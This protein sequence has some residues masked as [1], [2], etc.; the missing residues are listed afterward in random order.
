MAALTSNES[1]GAH[2][3]MLGATQEDTP[4]MPW[5]VPT[6]FEVRA[7]TRF[8]DSLLVVGSSPAL[9]SWEPENGLRMSTSASLYPV[10]R[11]DPLLLNEDGLEF[12]FVI[13]RS[14]GS[15][16]WEERGNRRLALRGA[17][18]TQVIAEW[19][20]DDAPSTHPAMPL[21]FFN[22]APSH[23]LPPVDQASS[24]HMNGGASRFRLIPPFSRSQSGK[25]A[26]GANPSSPSAA[27]VAAPN[28]GVRAAPLHSHTLASESLVLMTNRWKGCWWSSII[29]RSC[30]GRKGAHG[31]A[32]G[33]TLRYSPPPFRAVA[34]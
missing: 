13:R 4:P 12:K 21:P 10:W 5:F 32:N 6:S 27:E 9:G 18:E 11:C 7:D 2:L 16:E 30:S 29:C 28:H 1:F 33:T 26:D 3:V 20:G 24:A 17:E 34:T 31:L 19:N 23:M 15:F 25:S 8:G 14:D 22:K